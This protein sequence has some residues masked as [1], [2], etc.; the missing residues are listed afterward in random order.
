[1]QRT[2]AAIVADLDSLTAAD[3]DLNSIHAS[4]MERLGRMMDELAATASAAEAAPIILGFIERVTA[5][6][7]PPGSYEFGSPG[8]LVHTLEQLGGYEAHLFASLERRPAPLSVW[9][10]NRII[11]VTGDPT[12]RARLLQMLEQVTRHPTAST[13]TREEARRFLEFQQ[14]A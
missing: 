2:F 13:F 1:M 3:F 9:M 10:L 12:D 11:N 6:E 5:R 4:G 7:L 8:P 14:E